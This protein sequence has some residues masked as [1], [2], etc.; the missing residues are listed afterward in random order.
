METLFEE[1][2]KILAI[3]EARTLTHLGNGI[4]PTPEK[5]RGVFKPQIYDI[6][7]RRYLV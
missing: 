2:A 4:K 6:L 1:P 5:L 3:I 7:C